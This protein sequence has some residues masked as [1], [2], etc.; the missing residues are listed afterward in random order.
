MDVGSNSRTLAACSSSYQD[1]LTDDAV[2][3]GVASHDDAEVRVPFEHFVLG[4]ESRAH[5]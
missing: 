4:L 5:S 3:V 1:A 2:R